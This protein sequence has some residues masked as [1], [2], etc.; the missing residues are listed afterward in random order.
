MEKTEGS[1][2]LHVHVGHRNTYPGERPVPKN[3]DLQPYR[4]S[5]D[6]EMNI[7]GILPSKLFVQVFG[8][9]CDY[10]VF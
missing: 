2:D 5:V 10:G 4:Y 8:N 9:E 7:V 6:T 1:L 3:I